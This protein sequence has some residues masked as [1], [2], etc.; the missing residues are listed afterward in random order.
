M[1]AAVVD[2]AYDT[3][4]RVQDGLLA[5]LTMLDTEINYVGTIIAVDYLGEAQAATD[6]EGLQVLGWA[7]KQVDNT[8]DGKTIGVRNDIIRM[9]NDATY[10]FGLGHL[11]RGRVAYV[12]DDQT[13]GTYATNQIPAGLVHD[14]NSDG[15][16]VDMSPLA[17][18][19]ARNMQPAKVTNRTTD[20][21]CSAEQALLFSR[22]MCLNWSDADGEGLLTLP[23]AVPGMAFGVARTLATAGRDVQIQCATGDYIEGSDGWSAASKAVDN[24]VDLV[25]GV[26]TWWECVALLRWKLWRTNV[27]TVNW[28]ID[29]A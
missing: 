26:A 9:E 27:W 7:P 5:K 29:D 24:T 14:V 10:P 13:V 21:D 23:T 1:A 12:V 4:D 8:A 28:I 25:Q 11:G 19:I 16:F 20:Y 2:R 15:V 18:Q 22:R 6:T 3:I 17:M